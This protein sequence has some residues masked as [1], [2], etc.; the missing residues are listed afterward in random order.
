[1]NNKTIILGKLLLLIAAVG[2]PNL[3]L[4]AQIHGKDGKE[5]SI[6][7]EPFGDSMRH[8][9]GIRDESNIVNP[10][11]NQPRYKETQI[12][13]IADN[14]LLYQ[15]NDG[16]WPKNY[17]MQA[18]LTP[19]QVDSLLNTKDMTHTT[20]DNSTTW[21][22]VDYLAQVYT[23]THTEKYKTGCIN[24]IEFILKAQYPN[25]GWPQYY[26]IEPDKYSRRIT[27][28]DG[29]YMG[30]MLV[31]RKIVQNDPDYAFIDP[32]LRATVK[33]AYE[34]G[35][36]CILKMQI[37]D[38]GKL[39]AW[40]QQHDEVT[41]KP[42]WARAFEPPSICNGES[43]PIV[44]FLMAIDHPGPEIIKSVQSAVKWF[45]DSEILHT[46]E[47]TVPAPENK[48]KWRT[49]NYDR[50]AVTDPTAPPIWTRYY[51]L[52]TERPLFCDRN[53]KFLY[54]LSDV[55]RERRSG[56]GWYTY[57]PQ[58]VLDKYPAWQKKWAPNDN[59]LAQ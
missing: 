40:C 5:I 45:K 2:F 25:G 19:P 39:T 23:L 24:G 36:D 10:V 18:I 57:D 26:P 54:K 8:W 52:G 59:V 42:A 38:Q 47:E 37:V 53:S 44:L 28:N 11:K 16:G 49:T 4:Q 21:T 33:R 1:M 7:M 35:I 13:Q 3:Y 55:S 20:F 27:F 6:S 12:T 30:I 9:Y 48:S 22:H 14:I 34:K 32:D 31:L 56:Y 29:A 50:V 17:D 41:L 15:R 46:R 43:S 58:K 51:E